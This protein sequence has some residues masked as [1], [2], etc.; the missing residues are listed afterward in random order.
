MIDINNGNIII[1]NGLYIL[2]SG[3]Q[4]NEFINSGFYIENLIEDVSIYTRYFL[5]P[6]V[7]DGEYF[8]VVIYF[9]KNDLLEF[10]DLALMHN[11]NVPSWDNWSET[12]ERKRKDEHDK[13]LE[14]S[15][16]RPPYKYSWGEISSDYDPR[17]GSSTITIRY[18]L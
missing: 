2:K 16:G 18:K 14:K 12:E 9:N 1:N 17:S 7:I 4:K 6:Q 13:W 11:G 10:V 8:I 3:L 5:K 15:I